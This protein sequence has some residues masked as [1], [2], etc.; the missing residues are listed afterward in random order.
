[1]GGKPKQH[2]RRAI[3]L[4]PQGYATAHFWFA[5]DYLGMLGRW[6]EAFQE[7][8]VALQLD[9][10]SPIIREG[11]RIPADAMQEIRP[12]PSRNIA[13]YWTWTAS[14][15]R[16][17][18][19][20]GRCVHT[21]GNVR[22]SDL[23]AAKGKGRSSGVIFPASLGAPGADLCNGQQASRTRAGYWTKLAELATRR[24]VSSTLLRFDPSRAWGEKE[25]GA[26]LAGDGRARGR[27]NSIVGTQGSSCLRQLA[28]RAQVFRRY[29]GSLGWRAPL[30]A[31]RVE[32]RDRHLHARLPDGIH[33]GNANLSCRDSPAETC[34]ATAV[35][36][37]IRSGRSGTSPPRNRFQSF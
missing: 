2:Y 17:F 32:R 14:S 33:H 24:H 35:A 22:G 16:L 34:S 4:K 6:E 12:K 27:E 7:I 25:T 36:A 11:K 5:I 29:C 23:H 31:K 28:R 26:R 8:E 3:E 15:T 10:L 37:T 13:R 1:M 21:K 18:T 30:S 19:S 20:M 9:P